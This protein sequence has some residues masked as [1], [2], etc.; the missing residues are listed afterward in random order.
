MILIDTNVI[1]DLLTA[2]RTAA[3]DW[4]RDAYRSASA[5]GPLVSNHI[6]LAELAT[7]AA[8]PA[9]LR[10]DLDRLHIELRDLTDAAALCAGTAFAAYR[11]RG[12]ERTTILPDFL[13]AGHAVALKAALLTRDRRMARYF[14]DLTFITPETHPDG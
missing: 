2:D 7:G 11:Q 13:I 3:A 5:S 12:G 14:P 6:V 8:R 4:S 10:D 9:E 1:V